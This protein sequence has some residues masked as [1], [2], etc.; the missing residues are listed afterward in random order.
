M[1]PITTLR[2]IYNYNYW[3][4]DRQLEACKVLSP[5]HFLKPMGSSFSSVRDTLAHI[6]GAEC[7]WLERWKGNTAKTLPGVP[8]GLSFDET[9]RRW[10]Y[11]FPTL[12]AVSDR[13]KQVESDLRGHLAKLD[14]AALEKPLNYVNL[15]GK[16]HAYP[17][18]QTIFH[19]ANHSA[20]HR[21]QV[22]TL[23]RQHGAKACAVD[24]LDA[25]DSRK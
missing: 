17:L 24:F 9:F 2:E 1:I 18:W 21:G 13:W 8:E 10:S 19:V 25:V 6:M 5:E 12:D 7:I 16:P 15:Q 23:L 14:D 11:Q 4:R 3:A 20:Y 22:T